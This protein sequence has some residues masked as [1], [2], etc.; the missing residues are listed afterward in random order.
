MVGGGGHLT[1]LSYGFGH[2]AN[3]PDAVLEGTTEPRLNGLLPTYEEE[4]VFT[5]QHGLSVTAAQPSYNY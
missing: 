2:P 3:M 5:W 4:V 1:V